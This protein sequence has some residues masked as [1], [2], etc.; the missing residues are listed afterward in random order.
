[1]KSKKQRGEKNNKS[2]CEVGGKRGK[3]YAYL[4][5]IFGPII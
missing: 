5:L 1:M 2:S 3:K 4:F